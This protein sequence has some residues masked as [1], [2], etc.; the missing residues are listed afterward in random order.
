MGCVSPIYFIFLIPSPQNF[1]FFF[2]LKMILQKKCT[3]NI[4]IDR[5]DF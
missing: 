2:A 4:F 5:S 3:Y 1:A